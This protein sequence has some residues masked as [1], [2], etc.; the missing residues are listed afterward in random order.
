MDAVRAGSTERALEQ[1]KMQL[2]QY[3]IEAC[4]GNNH[5][6]VDK[7]MSEVVP[8]VTKFGAEIKL[9]AKDEEDARAKIIAAL[10]VEVFVDEVHREAS[11]FKSRGARGY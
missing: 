11:R 5:I 2:K 4:Q 7:A 9:P 6:E 1:V 3:A 10:G 8:H